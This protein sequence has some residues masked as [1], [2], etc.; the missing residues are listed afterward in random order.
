MFNIRVSA[1][2]TAEGHDVLRA[3]ERGQARSDD[4][5]ILQKSIADNR[6]LITL[7]E[8]FG[9]WVILPLS[10]HP[11]VIRIKVNPT[12]SE[13]IIGVLLP[14]LR[15]HSQEEFKDHLIIISEEK[16]K[17]IMTAL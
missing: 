2:L 10:R 9:D 7:D 8:H 15:N 5:E 16:A 6:I 14:F 3:S 13:K 11:G 4:K 17:W 1:A 12:T